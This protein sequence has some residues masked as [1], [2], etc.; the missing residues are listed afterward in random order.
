MINKEDV[1][2]K[3]RQEEARIKEGISGMTIAGKPAYPNDVSRSAAFE[4]ALKNSTEYQ[5]LIRH[6]KAGRKL[7]I[8]LICEQSLIKSTIL[9]LETL[10][11]KN[12]SL[13]RGRYPEKW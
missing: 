7:E 12:Q 2:D 4:L 10:L 3:I 11:E 13:L 5:K 8:N 6:R 9:K 1:P